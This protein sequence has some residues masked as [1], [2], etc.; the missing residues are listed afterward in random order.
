MSCKNKDNGSK[1]KEKRIFCEAC[2]CSKDDNDKLKVECI[3]CEDDSNKIIV[4]DTC[5]CVDDNVNNNKEIRL[6]NCSLD[7][8][9]EK[10]IYITCTEYNEDL[11]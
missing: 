4:C 11:N 10:T 8:C 9:E 7:G 3:N 1:K 2:T 5:K 6:E